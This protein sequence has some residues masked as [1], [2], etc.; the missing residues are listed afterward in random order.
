[1]PLRKQGTLIK[2]AST[3]TLAATLMMVPSS[4]SAGILSSTLAPTVNQVTTTVKQ[5]A[6]ASAPLVDAVSNVVVTPVAV[7]PPPTCTEAPTTKAFAK[8]G[9]QADYSPAPNGTFE[10]STVGW[11]LGKGATIVKG[12]DTL[13]VTSGSKSLKLATGA[14][15]TSPEFCVSEANPYFRF[16]VKAGFFF[17]TYQALVL[18]RDSAGTLT[19]AQFVSSQNTQLFPG[20]WTPSGVSPLAT[21][22][23]LVS[24]GK[25][26]SVQIVMASLFGGASVDSVMVDPYRRG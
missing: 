19:Q 3:A 23:P 21:K 11:K 1:M 5:V 4:A 10:D 12:N 17:S 15:A 16:V 26:A 7:T 24:G 13:G 20:I 6:P 2:I 18:Y 22:I 8:F 25:T 9:D 14:I